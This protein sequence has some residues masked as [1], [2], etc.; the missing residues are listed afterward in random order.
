MGLVVLKIREWRFRFLGYNHNKGEKVQTLTIRVDESYIDQ[1]LAFLQQIPKNK[2]EIFQHTKLNISPEK[3]EDD[4]F[5]T[6]L[7]NGPTISHKEADT[8]E[9]NIKQGYKSW[10][11]EEF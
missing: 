11:I 10:K 8:W 3:R 4:D 6:I 7:E 1:V 5:L 9:E 2:R